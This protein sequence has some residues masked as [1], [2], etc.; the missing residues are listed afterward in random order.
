MKDCSGFR[1][2]GPKYSVETRRDAGCFWNENVYVDPGADKDRDVQWQVF[3]SQLSGGKR[4]CR[5]L[6][7]VSFVT[8]FLR[9]KM[10]TLTLEP[11]PV[12]RHYRNLRIFR[13]NSNNCSLQSSSIRTSTTSHT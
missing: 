1:A 7:N 9:V 10:S 13:G 8:R 2:V 5:V 3:L 6:D 4:F 12:D 11:H